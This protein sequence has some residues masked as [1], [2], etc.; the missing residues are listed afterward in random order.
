MEVAY[1]LRCA[2][3]RTVL[4]LPDE[5][6][7]AWIWFLNQR[8]DRRQDAVDRWAAQGGGTCP[9]PLLIDSMD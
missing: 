7:D 1:R 4:A 6:L 2:D 3:P 5:V 9:L 8:T